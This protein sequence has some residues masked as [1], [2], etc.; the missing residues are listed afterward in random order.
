MMSADTKIEE[1]AKE[2][3]ADA[4]LKKPFDIDELENLL[5]KYISE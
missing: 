2:G 1:K 3:G 4:F 5:K